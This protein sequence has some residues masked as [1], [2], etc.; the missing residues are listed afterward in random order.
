MYLKSIYG[1]DITKIYGISGLTGLE[2]LSE[3]GTDMSKWKT[4]GHYVSWLGLSPNNK[5]SGGR[6]LSSSV[7]KKKNRAG[8]AFRM[9]ASTLWNS[10]NML[11][12]FYRRK[13]AIGGPAGANVATARKLA[14]IFYNMVKKQEGFAPIALEEY[15]EQYKAK[16]LKYLEKQLKKYGMVAVAT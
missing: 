5:I 12:D 11:G 13:R 6:L 3:V 4:A 8:Q 14:I 9:A 7:Q 15:Q 1:V 10:K 16:K 2:I